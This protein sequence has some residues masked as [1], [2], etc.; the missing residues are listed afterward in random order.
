MGSEERWRQS[1]GLTSRPLLANIYLNKYDEEMESR[2]VSVV[3]YADDTVVLAKSRR[4]AERLLESSR[5]YLEVKLK[6]KVNGDKSKVVSV[7][8]VRNFMFLGLTLGKSKK[9]YYR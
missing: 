2:G 4:A 3:R 8:S 6:L 7:L 1:S 9:G 5:K